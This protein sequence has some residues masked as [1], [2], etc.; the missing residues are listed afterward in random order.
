MRQIARKPGRTGATLV[1]LLA[2]IGI[3][4]MVLAIVVLAYRVFTTHANR[5]ESSAG[6]RQLA[7]RTLQLLGHDLQQL[8]FMPGDSNTVVVL[9]N[10]ATNLVQLGFSRWEPAPK[11]DGLPTNRLERVTFTYAPVDGQHQLVKVVG[12]LTG[13]AVLLPPVTNRPG[14]AWPRLAVHLHD[15]Q[16]WQTN[17]STEA[18]RAPVAARI[19]LLSDPPSTTPAHESI[20]VIPAGLSVTSRIDRLAQP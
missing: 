11:P 12:G 7:E 5:F 2:A 17:W 15:G 14:P 19:Q 4:V 1:E 3:G 6:R 9:E 18:K 8:F 20:V 16:Q 10:S 13:P